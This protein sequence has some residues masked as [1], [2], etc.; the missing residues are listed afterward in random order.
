LKNSPANVK[1]RQLGTQPPFSLDPLL[2]ADEKDSVSIASARPDSIHGGAIAPN[3]ERKVDGFMAKLAQYLRDD[4][5]ASAAEYALILALI[6]AA[7]I[8]ALTA[9]GTSIKNVLGVLANNISAS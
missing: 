4:S 5:G 6:A 3:N 2:K 1:D 9:L 7:I 8:T